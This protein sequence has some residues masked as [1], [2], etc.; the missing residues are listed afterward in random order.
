MNW[1]R[2]AA[3]A[4]LLAASGFAALD[5][6]Q[7]SGQKE[8]FTAVAIVNN[9][10]SSG[11]GTII[12]NVDRWSTDN[13][14]TALVETLTGNRN[15][16]TVFVV[17][18]VR[19]LIGLFAYMDLDA[20]NR[21]MREGPV[22]SGGYLQVD[23][24]QASE[25][26]AHL[27]STPGIGSV[28]ISDVARRS[29]EETLATVISTVTTMFGVFGA[30]IAFAVIYN[31]SR[32]AF[33]ERA[34]ELGSL[35]V[36]GFSHAEMAEIVLGEMAILTAIA[37]PVGLLAGRLLGALVVVLFSTELARIPLVIAPSTNGA[38]DSTSSVRASTIFSSASDRP[39]S[40]AMMPSARETAWA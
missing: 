14:Q 11:A 1:K 31:N 24:A 34:R 26:Y 21:L 35:H 25:L 9:N 39:A 22:I 19:D 23:A 2:L 27:K 30:A 5:A 29:F 36:L 7:T 4:A 20:V 6:A 8:E 12:I 33:A 38:A 3:T 37:I 32:I 40:S 18:I 15:R 10:L 17:G 16:R 28:T 13:E